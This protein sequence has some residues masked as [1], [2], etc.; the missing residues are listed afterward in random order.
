MENSPNFLSSLSPNTHSPNTQ[1]NYPSP[2]D[3][4]PDGGGDDGG[5]M[6]LGTE[7]ISMAERVRRDFDFSEFYSLAT[8]VMDGDGGSLAKL[9]ELKQ[10]WEHRFPE[11][12]TRRAIPRF[13]S[14]LTFLPRR[15]IVSPCVPTSSHTPPE[16]GDL[17]LGSNQDSGDSGEVEIRNSAPK[18]QDL[19]EGP[20]STPDLEVGTS[21]TRNQDSPGG[22]P[23][24][25]AGTPVPEVF[26][27]NVRLQ[28]PCSDSIAEAFLNSSRKTLRYIPP[29]TQRGEIIIKP[30]AEMVTQGARRWQSTAVGYFLGRRPYFPHLEAFARANWK[31]LQQVS[32]TANGFYFFRFRNLAFMEEIIEEGPWLFQ[33]QPVVLQQWEQ[34]MSLRRQK[35]TKVPVWIR[36]RHLPMEFWTED[37]LSA[38]ASGVGTPLYTDKITKNCSRLDFARVCVMLDFQSKLPKHLVVLSPVVSEDKQIPIKIDIEYE[39]LPLRCTQCCSLGHTAP[40]CPDTKVKKMGPP[41]AV[42]LQKKR[43]KSVDPAQHRDAEVDDT[44]AHVERDE[45]SDWTTSYGKNG[46]NVADFPATL[47]RNISTDSSFLKNK[48]KG[49]ELIVYN[50]FEILSVDRVELEE[51]RG[52][53]RS[54]ESHTGPIRCSPSA[55]LT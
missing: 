39:W 9:V 51:P 22:P 49:K 33:G 16:G 36:L 31:G 48:D 21:A 20:A 43:T 15:N 19:S 32:A 35:H 11:V 52:Q 44:Y 26:V 40:N 10:R 37:G 14:T 13:P 17:E 23:P 8:R 7:E 54:G 25:T 34:G 24:S 47:D 6:G 4:E 41:M 29:M 55:G 12:R 18:V 45:A 27:G 38:V 1:E 5:S 53:R 2:A 28:M 46:G 3:L 30:T 50:P 42:Y